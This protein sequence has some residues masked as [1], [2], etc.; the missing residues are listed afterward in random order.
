VL[1]ASGAFDWSPLIGF[2]V[3]SVVAGIVGVG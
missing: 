2:L 1:P 3:L